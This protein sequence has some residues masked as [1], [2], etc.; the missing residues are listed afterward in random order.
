[1]SDETGRMSEEDKFLGVKTTIVSPS[2]TSASAQV[3]EIDV[4]V[5]DDRPED[6][7]RPAGEATSS[8]D[9]IATDEEISKY[10]S[11][12]QKRIK[13]LKWEFHEERRAKEASERLAGEAVNYTQNLQVENQ[14][15][16]KLIQDSQSALT[17]HSKYGAEAAVAIAEANFKQAHES[18]ESDQIAA[19]Q[20]ALTNAQLVQAS[21]PAISDKVVENWKQNVLA[22]QRQQAQQQPAPPPEAPP[23]DPAAVEWQENNPW[24]GNDE[25]MTSF[26]YG[27]HERLV[28]KEGVDPETQQYYELIDK[29]MQEVFPDYFGTNNQSSSEPVVVEAATRRKTSPVVAPAMRNNGAMPRKV[30]LTSTQVALAKRLGI[31]PQQYASQLIKEM[32]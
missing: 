29:R 32:V 9:D 4:E 17:Q 5:V 14:R 30:T 20:K 12:A 27:V 21:A 10:G 19:A 18:G 22:E 7:Q 1:M 8:D 6:D 24:F 2:D 31:T 16:L 23:A 3:D 13:K 28:R 26:A 15:L 11:R 25:E